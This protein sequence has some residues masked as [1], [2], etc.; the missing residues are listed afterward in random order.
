[1]RAV[2]P[3]VFEVRLSLTYSAMV[4]V[5]DEAMSERN[6][7]ERDLPFGLAIELFQSFVIDQVDDPA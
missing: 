3:S 1:M 4:F 6:R 2:R 7:V 5:W